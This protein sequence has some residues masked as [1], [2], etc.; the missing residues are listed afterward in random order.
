MIPAFAAAVRDRTLDRS[1]VQVYL[2]LYDRLDVLEFRAIK[3]SAIQVDLDLSEPT[4]RF[5][6]ERLVERGYLAVGP[7]DDRVKTYRLFHSALTV[8]SAR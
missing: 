1:A 6:I 4:V 7:R 3:Q 2:W 5:A 8:N